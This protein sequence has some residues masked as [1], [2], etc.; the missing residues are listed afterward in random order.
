MRGENGEEIKVFSNGT[1]DPKTVIGTDLED[2]GIKGK[3]KFSVLL[4]IAQACDGDLDAIKEMCA[5]RA[6]NFHQ[7]ILPR[8]TSLHLSTIVEFVV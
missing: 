1:V 3:V 4:E 8:T 6:A 5:K 7:S 2:I